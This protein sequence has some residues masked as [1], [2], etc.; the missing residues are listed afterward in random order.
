LVDS[1]AKKLISAILF[2]FEYD[3][4]LEIISEKEISPLPFQWALAVREGLPGQECISA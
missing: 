1:Y 4:L 2:Q 3:E